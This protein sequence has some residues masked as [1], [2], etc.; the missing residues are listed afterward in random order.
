MINMIAQLTAIDSISHA[1]KNHDV[2][3]QSDGISKT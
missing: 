3:S 2:F 1:A